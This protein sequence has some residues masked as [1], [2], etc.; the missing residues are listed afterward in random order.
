MYARPSES[1][2]SAYPFRGV[3][4]PKSLAIVGARGPGMVTRATA[5]QVSLATLVVL[6]L[7]ALYASG[8]RPHEVGLSGAHTSAKGRAEAPP[9]LTA[10]GHLASRPHPRTSVPGSPFVRPFAP[11]WH[12]PAWSVAP[13]TAP[14]ARYVVV[15]VRRRHLLMGGHGRLGAGQV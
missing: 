1:A 10:R 11:G 14:A 6:A 7:L 9:K 4:P 2:G 13:L 3:Y 12:P 15:A 5:V 8:E